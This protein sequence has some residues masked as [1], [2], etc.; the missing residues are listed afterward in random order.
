MRKAARAPRLKINQQTNDDSELSL[1]DPSILLR[2]DS[3]IDDLLHGMPAHLR[4]D[5][6]F[7][8]MSLSEGAIKCFRIQ[9]HAL[10]FRLLLLRVFLLRPS[11]LAEAQRWTTRNP[12]STHT[13]SLMLQE[14]FHQEICELCLTTVHT[15]LSEIHGSLASNVG[16]SAWYALHCESALPCV[17]GK[18]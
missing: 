16:M 1:P 15:V 13:A 6:N 18:A 2:V 11:L 5:A 4:P 9:G 8:D 17:L 14:R 3:K 7:S 12:G 10:R